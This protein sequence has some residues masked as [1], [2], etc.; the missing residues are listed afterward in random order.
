MITISRNSNFW[1][2]CQA[3]LPSCARNALFPCS[4][5]RITEHHDPHTS[6][7]NYHVA[8]PNG[9]FGCGSSYAFSCFHYRLTGRRTSPAGRST[10]D[11]SIILQE[12]ENARWNSTGNHLFLS[13]ISYHLS[14]VIVISLPPFSY[15]PVSF[16]SFILFVLPPSS[17]QKTSLQNNNKMEQ[18]VGRFPR[19]PPI[20]HV[21]IKLNRSFPI[22]SACNTY[23][24]L[25]AT[26]FT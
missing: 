19:G 10:S 15:F 16:L 22:S 13:S 2:C 21:S 9:R 26:F 20:R 3:R 1:R 4:S 17:L 18:V 7:R 24:S 8:C 23:R 11:V 5:L 14:F 25:K 12:R 6:W